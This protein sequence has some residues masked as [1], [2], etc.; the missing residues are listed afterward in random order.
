MPDK[1]KYLREEIFE[2]EGIA[3]ITLDRPEKK[4]AMNRQLLAE[5]IDCL[6]KL[7]ENRRIRC[8]VTTGTGD[9]YSSG[10]D[11]IDHRRKMAA[12]KAMG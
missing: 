9:S 7:R 1:E 6:K 3:W 11:L 2:P 8:I 12:K 10:L 5:L 4:N